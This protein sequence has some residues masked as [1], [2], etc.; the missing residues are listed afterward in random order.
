MADEEKNVVD[1]S[2]NDDVHL[3]P[4]LAKNGTHSQ[5]K[6][7]IFGALVVAELLASRWRMRKQKNQRIL[8]LR[9]SDRESKMLRS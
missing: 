4:A 3:K 7:F 5:P 8:E 2:S 1:F 9:E 6:T